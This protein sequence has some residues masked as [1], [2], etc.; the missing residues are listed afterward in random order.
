MSIHLYRRVFVMDMC[1]LN[2]IEALPGLLGNKV[3]RIYLRGTREQ[4]SKTEENRGTKAILGNR[5][6]R[7][8]KILIMGI[9]GIRPFLRGTREQKSKTEENRGTKAILGNREHR[10]SRI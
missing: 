7:K 5:E 6:H 8:I 2:T 3:I 10:K 4:K 1:L 9:M